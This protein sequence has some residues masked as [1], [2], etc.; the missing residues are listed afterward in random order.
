MEGLNQ[1][2]EFLEKIAHINME[3]LD[4]RF[5]KLFEILDKIRQNYSK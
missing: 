1:E 5:F 2:Q 3:K 4:E